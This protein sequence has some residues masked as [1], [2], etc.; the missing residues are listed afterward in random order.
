MRN[1][2]EWYQPFRQELLQYVP[3]GQD[4]YTFCATEIGL[5][6]LNLLW[7]DAPAYLLWALMRGYKFFSDVYPNPDPT[8]QQVY[9]NMRILLT[10]YRNM[11]DWRQALERYRE[12][13]SE[14]TLYEIDPDNAGYRQ[15]KISVA[16]E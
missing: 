6:G 3:A 10:S 9:Q 2:V 7:P 11:Y 8:L 15:K 13:G 5:Y 4:F 16:H 14:C 1:T 12:H